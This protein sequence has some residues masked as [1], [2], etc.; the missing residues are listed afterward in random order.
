MTEAQRLL[1]RT[2]RELHKMAYPITN[3]HTLRFE[4]C[5]EAICSEARAYLAQPMTTCEGLTE[6]EQGWLREALEEIASDAVGLCHNVPAMLNRLAE[7]R[8]REGELV[9][10]LEELA[11]VI[12][13]CANVLPIRASNAYRLACAALAQ[14][15]KSEGVLE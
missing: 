11:K 2:I 1:E 6:E 5:C 13:T 8:A 9:A 7:S 4:N 3:C 15:K 12:D 10:A 14:G